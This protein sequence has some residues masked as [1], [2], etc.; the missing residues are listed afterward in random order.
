MRIDNLPPSTDKVASTKR[1]S[2]E[3]PNPQTAGPA[4]D[5]ANL[6]QLSKALTQAGA[7]E[8]RIEHLRLGVASETYQIDPLQISRKIVDEHL[9]Q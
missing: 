7:E 6:S 8:P 3:K 4:K 1:T 2:A 9:K 5:Q